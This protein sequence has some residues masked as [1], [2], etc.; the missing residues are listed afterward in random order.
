[1]AP[2]KHIQTDEQILDYLRETTTTVYHPVGTCKMG[3]DEMAVVDPETL[4]VKGMQN[5]RVMDA[6]VMPTLISGNTSA[7]S[8]MIGEKVRR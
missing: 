1:M 4:K 3:I 7:P 2:G 6:S 5:L 8:M